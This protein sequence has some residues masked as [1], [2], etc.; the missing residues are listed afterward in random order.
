[1]GI[2]QI[3]SDAAT[4]LANKLK[5]PLTVATNM[6]VKAA[7]RITVWETKTPSNGQWGQVETGRDKT[8]GLTLWRQGD[9]VVNWTGKVG[10]K[11]QET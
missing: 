8:T 2:M 1:M 6:L 7:N 11:P 9:V 10:R 3:S 4:R 5:Q